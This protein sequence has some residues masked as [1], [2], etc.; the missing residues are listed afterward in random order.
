MYERLSTK[1][2]APALALAP[3]REGEYDAYLLGDIVEKL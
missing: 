1:T 2:L 3:Y